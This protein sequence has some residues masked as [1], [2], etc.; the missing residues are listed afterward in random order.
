M[1]VET[2]P[3]CGHILSNEVVCTLPP[4]PVKICYFC[5]WRW[6]SEPEEIELVPFEVD[7]TAVNRKE[8]KNDWNNTLRL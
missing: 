1:I 7:Y 3:T 8:E 6:E 2:C 4:I 5:G